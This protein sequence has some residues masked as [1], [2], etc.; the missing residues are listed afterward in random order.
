MSVH[1]LFICSL[2]SQSHFANAPVIS[3]PFEPPLPS[4]SYS[5][6]TANYADLSLVNE[7]EEE[8]EEGPEVTFMHYEDA[9]PSVRYLD[10]SRVHVVD[11]R[12]QATSGQWSEHQPCPTVYAQVPSGKQPSKDYVEYAEL[13]LSGQRTSRRF[14]CGDIGSPGVEYQTVTSIAANPV[15][16][17]GEG[18]SQ[19][20]QRNIDIL[21]TKLSPSVSGEQQKSATL[22]YSKR[23]SGYVIESHGQPQSSSTSNSGGSGS[24]DFADAILKVCHI[25]DQTNP[26]KS[27]SNSSSSSTRD[28]AENTPT[29]SCSV[30]KKSNG[31]SANILKDV[32]RCNV[33]QT[34]LVQADGTL[35]P[36]CNCAMMG[37]DSMGTQQCRSD[38]TD[39][40]DS[41]HQPSL[42]RCQTEPILRDPS[43]LSQPLQPVNFSRYDGDDDGEYLYWLKGNKNARPQAPVFYTTV[44]GGQSAQ[45]PKHGDRISAVS[46]ASKLIRDAQ[47]V[48]IPSDSENEIKK[49]KQKT[50]QWKNKLL[51]FHDSLRRNKP[52]NSPKP[53]DSQYDG[54]YI[55]LRNDVGENVPLSRVRGKSLENVLSGGSESP[56]RSRAGFQSS[57]P[58]TP[59]RNRRSGK[60]LPPPFEPAPAIP[61]KTSDGSANRIYDQ[62]S[63]P[64][65]IYAIPVVSNSVSSTT[66]RVFKTIQPYA[67]QNL[68][69]GRMPVRRQTVCSS[70]FS[71]RRNQNQMRDTVFCNVELPPRPSYQTSTQTSR[72]DSLFTDMEPNH[73]NVYLRMNVGSGNMDPDRVKSLGRSAS[74]QEGPN[75]HRPRLHHSRSLDNELDGDGCSYLEM[76]LGNGSAN[77]TTNTL[78]HA[79]VI[80]ED[81]HSNYMPMSPGAS[82]Y[83]SPSQTVTI[84]FDN[85]IEHKHHSSKMVQH[86]T[87]AP[88]SSIEEDTEK[89]TKTPGLLS[90]LMRRNSSH[91]ELKDKEKKQSKLD[92]IPSSSISPVL[93]DPDPAPSE[94]VTFSNNLS[95]TVTYHRDSDPDIHEHVPLASGYRSRSNSS[96]VIDT[97]GRRLGLL[98]E[99][100]H[101]YSYL[102]ASHLELEPSN[103]TA[104]RGDSYS[105][106]LDLP[107][108][109]PPPLPNRAAER[110]L[111]DGVNGNQSVSATDAAGAPLLPP[112]TYREQ[113]ET[114]MEMN[115][116]S[117]RTMTGSKADSTR[118]KMPTPEPDGIG[119]GAHSIKDC[120]PPPSLPQKNVAVKRSSNLSFDPTSENTPLLNT[121]SPAA[122]ASNDV[123]ATNSPHVVYYNET[124]EAS[125]MSNRK[126]MKKAPNL[127]VNVPPSISATMAGNRVI[128]RSE[129]ARQPGALEEEEEDVWMLRELPLYGQYCVFIGQNKVMYC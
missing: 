16:P 23:H 42:L 27:N 29:V 100:Q 59:V 97:S 109:P 77:G 39:Q 84:P 26:A 116:G 35:A 95:N 107:P 4:P 33:C 24:V 110:P 46:V 126:P 85:L 53:V 58:G 120:T 81:N 17:A 54:S 21:A 102:D 112:K 47:Y 19:T 57:L 94:A 129:S 115:N 79:S 125:L 122:H 3:A 90:R 114:Y 91:K 128:T 45:S 74:V 123:Q 60:R 5:T 14:S 40:R 64:D 61:V 8:E 99:R 31:D 63:K 36:P 1:L 96:H 66:E 78:P 80:L 88:K 49:S 72:P 6:F 50:K 113:C 82:G 38:C 67:N 43:T 18:I 86:N 108:A 70:E 124:T 121:G 69:S 105:S 75:R 119:R 117:H 92:D 83:G 73:E 22:P 71:S 93:E 30:G 55:L 20:M 65:H 15:L 62:H 41:R 111:P 51:S 37:Y 52:K 28:L 9:Q 12:D 11:A 118:S 101:P 7:E 48:N 25:D 34:V 2:E 104:Q 103:L 89:S 106:L 56:D 127:R 98:H 10:T 13:Q 68:L 44:D 87:R 32:I 76:N